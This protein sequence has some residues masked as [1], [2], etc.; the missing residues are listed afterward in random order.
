[1]NIFTKSVMKERTIGNPLRD[2]NAID[3]RKAYFAQLTNGRGFKLP[4]TGKHKGQY[5]GH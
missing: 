3:R 1:M 2:K 5:V 4:K